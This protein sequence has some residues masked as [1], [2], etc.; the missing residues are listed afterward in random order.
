MSLS[1][2]HASVAVEP[3]HPV[4]VNDLVSFRRSFR[5]CLTARGEAL[6]ELTGAVLCKNGPVTTLVGLSL[7]GEHRRGHGALYD[8]LA[9]G[10]I[11][12]ER[13]RTAVA[14][15]LPPPRDDQGRDQA[16]RGFGPGAAPEQWFVSMPGVVDLPVPEFSRITTS[17]LTTASVASECR[18][19][20]GRIAV[21]AD[22]S[23][24]PVRVPIPPSSAVELDGIEWVVAS[25]VAADHVPQRD[26]DM[27]SAL[28]D[29][30][31]AGEE[32][33]LLAH[34][35]EDWFDAELLTSFATRGCQRV[36]AGLDMPTHS[37]GSP[38]LSDCFA[39]SGC[40]AT[41]SGH[42]SVD[43][44][45][46][47]KSASVVEGVAW[48]GDVHQRAAADGARHGTP[49]LTP[50]SGRLG[51]RVNL[52]FRTDSMAAAAPTTMRRYA[53]SL[54]V[55]LEFL[56]VFG[57]TW[58]AA[59]VRDVEAFKDWRLTDV[60]NREISTI[61]HLTV[62]DI[63]IDNETI[64][65]NIR[66]SSPHSSHAAGRTDPKTHGNPPQQGQDRNPR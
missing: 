44:Y 63:Q 65:I 14:A 56:G 52:F 12:P 59:T 37:R 9:A 17:T 41:S 7:V 43:F 30:G 19:V 27:A 54:A 1:V 61:S 36:L 35:V 48:F 64:A 33:R 16:G 42:W 23:R 10:G 50:L 3:T 4:D 6:F 47:Y 38:A 49:I 20:S 8:G 21:C 62:D 28:A 40:L 58:D 15:A 46:F 24:Q 25:A 53:Y 2:P 11:A 34:Y 51:P 26:I 57:R 29:G 39:G 66:S 55:W 31:G 22:R 5:N 60:R 45:D 32:Q 18:R 13:V